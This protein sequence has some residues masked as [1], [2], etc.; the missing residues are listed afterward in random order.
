MGTESELR[1]IVSTL[2]QV[3]TAGQ[4]RAAIG[5]AL[6]AIHEAYDV[7]DMIDD[8]SRRRAAINEL[9]QARI[10]LER[11]YGKIIPTGAADYR[12]EWSKYRNLVER[13]Y[14]TIAGVEGTAGYRPRTSNWEILRE[15]VKEGTGTVTD[16]VT[17]A[18]DL[19]GKVVGGAAGA[20][21]KGAGN[22]LGGLF[23]GL[24][25]S[26]TLHLVVIGALVLLFLNRG[27]V[28]GRVSGLLGKVGG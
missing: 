24:G 18:A 13:A 10:G 16:V 25:F 19:A 4:V 1:S 9:D 5:S 11:W 8:A 15:S 2:N 14:I 23:S 21:G 17:G 6:V 3:R 12:A 7:A 22:L 20:A 27:T 26:G 28:I